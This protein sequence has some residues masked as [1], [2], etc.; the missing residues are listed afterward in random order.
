MGCEFLFG[1]RADVMGLPPTLRDGLTRYG[2]EHLVGFWDRL[3]AAGRA[4]LVADLES[5]DFAQ[6]AALYA[7]RD[8][9]QDVRSLAARAVSPPSCRYGH[10]G[11][12]IARAEAV[13]AGRA[14]LR[15]GQV[16]AILVAGGQGTRLG[17]DHP[18]GMYPIGPVSGR[19]LFAIHAEKIVAT[20]RRCG[21]G[22]P[23]T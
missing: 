23:F 1:G 20:A 14:A 5:I 12:G 3:D 2:Q 11:L 6:V 7:H 22:V 4:A 13:E 9:A 17:F 15:E 8:A 19:S 16:A 10:G 21:A 18:K